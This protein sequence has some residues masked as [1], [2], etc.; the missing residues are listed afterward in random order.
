MSTGWAAKEATWFVRLTGLAWQG[1]GASAAGPDY[2]TAPLA[3]LT[4]AA[5]ATRTVAF[6]AAGVAAVQRWVDDPSSNFGLVTFPSDAGNNAFG[7]Q[8]C[9]AVDASSRLTLSIVTSDSVNHIFRDG[10][11]PT[12][13]YGGCAV[14]T[15]F[16]GGTQAQNMNGRGLA[17]GGEEA[18]TGLV[19]FDLRTIPAS[20]TVQSVTL[21]LHALDLSGVPEARVVLRPWLESSA[22]FLTLDGSAAWG[23]PGANGEG[24]VG[25]VLQSLQVVNV[26]TAE[27]LLGDAGVAAVQTWV[28]DPT[29][30]HGFAL[31]LLSESTFSDREDAL[32]ASRP[33]LEVTYLVA[34]AGTAA[35]LRLRVGNSCGEVP[36]S[37][38]LPGLL[39]AFVIGRRR[40]D[41]EDR[42]R[43]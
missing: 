15:L 38:L 13:G 35:P 5:N 34:D 2:A 26:P 17:A 28:R 31:T 24:D 20:A 22:T 42:R 33:A 32:P 41:R 21:R 14:T 27:L 30:N 7:L 12:P 10:V 4:G 1:D 36:S 18:L 6:N 3:T 40:M 8:G 23:M 39:L 19:Q 37:A 16:N 43:G 11:S 9:D 25:P 29:T